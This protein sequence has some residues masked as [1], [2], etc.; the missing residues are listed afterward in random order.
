LGCRRTADPSASLGM[1]KGRLV[2]PLIVVAWDGQ[3]GSA[4]VHSSPNFG[5][6]PSS[7]SWEFSAVPAGRFGPDGWFAFSK[8]LG[9]T[10]SLGF[11]APA[12]VL[13]QYLR[14]F[15]GDRGGKEMALA[16]IAA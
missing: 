1:T 6:R 2:L 9:E 15:H 4:D 3:S 14:L 8:V 11:D 12:A 16:Q 5:V 7:Q 13:Q 10:S